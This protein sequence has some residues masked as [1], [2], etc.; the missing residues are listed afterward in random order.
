M[1][2]VLLLTVH[3]QPQVTG[4]NGSLFDA[5]PIETPVGGLSP[6]PTGPFALPLGIPQEQNPGCLTQANQYSAWSCKMTF[7]PLVLTIND[8]TVG[9]KSIQVASMGR[10]PSVPN[11][12]I[13]YGLQTPMLDLKPMEL[14]LDLDYK[15]YGPAYHFSAR[16]DKL[17]VLPP[18]EL[19]F[20]SGLTKRQPEK[21]RQRFEVK[22]G[23][24]PWFCYWNHTYIEGYIYSEDNS[25][26]ASL[27]SFPTQWP[28]ATSSI[29]QT[30]VVVAVAT[31]AAASTTSG[32]QTMAFPP[33]TVVQ[34]MS[35]SS[36]SPI[37]ARDAASDDSSPL[38][39]PPYP[40]I[41]KIEERRLPDSPQP[42]C[43]QMVLLDNGEITSAPSPN[44]S[45]IRI[46]LQET[47]PSYEEYFARPT[48]TETSTADRRD[49]RQLSVQHERRS[50][51]PDAC[52][53]QWMF[54]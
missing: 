11:G 1:T 51:P 24:A 17:V 15:A 27:T 44:D 18:E 16:Y 20:G 37:V 23:D 38:R 21:Y 46:W 52:H 32:P 19:N 47:D 49:K 39:M 8:T 33:A 43:Q 53:C 50:D 45:P 4:Q 54:K 14:V 29:P 10:G 48:P 31:A 9:G 5:V 42:Y 35:P 2:L 6:L 34:P 13:L 3:R 12:A 28:T 22:P 30:A 26:A 36:P 7:A 25:T 41:V 40:R